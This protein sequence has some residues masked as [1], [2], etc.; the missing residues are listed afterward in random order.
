MD[1]T[2]SQWNSF[3]IITKCLSLTTKNNR[4]FSSEPEASEIKIVIANIFGCVGFTLNMEIMNCM[5]SN[6]N[7]ARSYSTWE[8]RHQ[9]WLGC[10]IEMIFPSISSIF[11]GIFILNSNQCV[12]IHW[13]FSHHIKSTNCGLSQDKSEESFEIMVYQLLNVAFASHKS[14]IFSN[15]YGMAWRKSHFDLKARTNY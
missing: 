12:T 4:A 14:Q 7:C 6:Q 9:I 8:D 10:C 5:T 3:E 13:T 1:L 11:D 15:R 2:C